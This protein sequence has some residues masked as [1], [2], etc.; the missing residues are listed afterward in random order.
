MDVNQT[1][2]HLVYGQA[3]WSPPSVSASPGQEPLFDW[4]NTDATLSLHRELFIFPKPRG[5]A[6]LGV[7]NRRDAARDRYGN[8]YW[9]GPQRDEI[10]FLGYGQKL[11]QHFWSAGDGACSGTTSNGTFFVPTPPATPNLLMSGLTVTTDHYLVVGLLSP[12]GLLIFDLH[13]GGQPLQMAWPASVDFAPFDMTATADGGLAILDRSNKVY[14]EFD[15]YLRI[16]GQGTSVASSGVSNVFQRVDGT[17]QPS[18]LQA[19]PTQITANLAISLSE[20][21]DPVAIEALPDGSVFI[22]ENPPPDSPPRSYSVVHWLQHGVPIAP[23]FTLKGALTQLVEAPADHP[24]L[25]DIR[26]YDIAYLPDAQQTLSG[27]LYIAGIEGEQVFALQ[28]G[29]PSSGS[30]LKVLPAYF[31]MRSFGGKAIVAAAQNIYYD[32]EDRWWAL[33]EQARARYVSSARFLLPNASGN[34]SSPNE[35]PAFDGKQP[36]CV[37]HRLL[38]DMCVPAGAQVKIETRAADLRHLLASAPWRPEPIPYLR[39]DG[40]EIPFYTSPFSGTSDRAGTWELLFQQAKGRYLQLR[41]TLS[42]TGRN[43]PRLHALRAYYPRFSYLRQY[44]PAVYRDDRA[45]SSFLDRYLANVEG[46]YTVLEGK[47]EQAQFLFDFHAIPAEYLDWLAG[48]VGLALDSNWTE[49]TRRLVLSHAP[50]M[51]RQRG[52]RAGMIRD[53]R[54]GLDPCPDDSLFEQSSCWSYDCPDQPIQTAFTVRVVERFLTRNAPGVLFGDPT[55]VVGPGSTTSSSAWTPAQGSGPLNQLFQ[56]YLQGLY[57]T[58]SSLNGAWGTTYSSFTDSSLLLPAIQPLSKTQAD[59]WQ[60]FL[61]GT[62]GFTYVP[63]TSNDRQTYQQFLARQYSLISNLNNAYGLT[64]TDAYSGFDSI[65]LPAALPAGGRSLQDWIQFVSDILPT[66]RNAH[67]FTVLVPVLPSDTP[68][69]QLKKQGVA[70][71]IAALE[72]PAHTDFDVRLYWGMFRVGEA[73]VGLDTLLG[74]SSRSVALVL[75]STYLA[76]G[77]LSYI[78]PWNITDRMTIGRSSAGPQCCGRGPQPRCT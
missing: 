3:E 38:L 29:E 22:L 54:L 31:P 18:N 63:V 59:D 32:F 47:I 45:S 6:P 14:W 37:W 73:R 11:F 72:K 74:Q 66:Q 65:Q 40:P 43:T 27:E 9:I 61:R 67:Q 46:F 39:D 49:S 75:G 19:Y 7:E 71:T 5:Q 13:G 1:R 41:L 36:G 78:E 48:W 55:D 68:D 4:N 17:P 62:I 64:G 2:Y 70:Q 50:Q 8:W 42:G 16:R 57:G 28:V 77:Y 20:L 33:T 15:R 44:L 25:S 12:K 24:E 35:V 30:W 23:A 53:I 58:I 51:F 69:V 26:G 10:R 21:Q 56:Q 52:T 76:A 34:P 60:R